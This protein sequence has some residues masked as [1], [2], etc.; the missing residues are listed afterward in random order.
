MATL[1]TRWETQLNGNWKSPK[2]LMCLNLSLLPTRWET[3]LNGNLL[4]ITKLF[5]FGE[6]PTR[7]ETQLK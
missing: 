5:G 3:Q 6:L 7:W 4:N 1:P 2:K